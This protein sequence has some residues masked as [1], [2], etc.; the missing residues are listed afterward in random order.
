MDWLSGSERM[1]RNNK[2][3][4]RRISDSP[5]YTQKKFCDLLEPVI[6]ALILLEF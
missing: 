2:F 6:T 5:F 4:N 3:L 1:L